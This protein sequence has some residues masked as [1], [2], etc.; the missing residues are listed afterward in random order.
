MVVK[1]FMINLIKKIK[2]RIPDK[3]YE[4][5]ID[6]RNRMKGGFRKYYYSQF[7]EDILINKLLKEEHGFY[8]DV[9]A[10]HPRHFSNTYLLHHRKHWRGIN[11][12]P[13]PYSIKLFNKFRKNDINLEIG[14]GKEKSQKILYR[15]SHSN[16]NTFSEE[17]ANTWRQI[18]SGVHFL[19]QDNVM[20]VPLQ[21]VLGQYLPA[22]TYI[23]LLNIDAEGLDLDVLESNDWEKYAP[24]VVTVE[25]ANFDPA[26]MEDSAV[27][28]F[29]IG[30]GYVLYAFVGLSLIFFRNGR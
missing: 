6:L 3:Y 5:F 29:L 1:I 13:N 10:Y 22:D 20:C 7:G 21:D 14:I 8:V 2:S 15:F 17:K 24:K 23:G 4:F 16:W 30:R 12:D 25:C 18:N 27:Y 26:H 9:G 19:G 28:L 11:I